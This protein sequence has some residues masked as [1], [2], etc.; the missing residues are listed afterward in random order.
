MNPNDPN[1][2]RVL[3]VAQALGPLRD[4][5]VFLGGCATGL[6]VT[7]TARPPVRATQDVDLV[8]EVSGTVEYYKLATSLKELGFKEHVGDVA[9]RWQLRD[10]LVDVMPTDERI[11]GFSNRWYPDAVRSAQLVN[12]PNNVAIMLVSP[13]LLVATKLEA[14]YGRGNGDY[15]AS[16]DVEDIVTLVDGRAELAAEI[17]AASHDLRE[18]LREEIEDLLAERRFTETLQWHLAPADIE[19]GRV[20]VVIGRLRGI[21]G[22]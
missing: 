14:F 9:C 5:L 18:Y 21:A 1:L 2:A 6:L 12:L 11:L 20:E 8:T 15:G 17:A 7:D 16:H 13:P 10:L 4:Q 22:L 3:T 19:Q